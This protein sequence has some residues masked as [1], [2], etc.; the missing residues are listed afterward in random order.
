M[1]LESNLVSH[2]KGWK[3]T[4]FYCKNT[5]PANENPLLG[6]RLEWIDKKSGTA[7]LANKKGER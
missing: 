3:K 4:W 1:F 7:W 6:Y 5:A 2:P